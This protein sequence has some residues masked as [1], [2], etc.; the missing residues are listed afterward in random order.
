MKTKIVQ[1]THKRN[2]DLGSLLMNR[3]KL[4]L[5]KEAR[6]LG[7]TLDS[8]LTWKQRITRITRKA[9]TALMQCRQIVG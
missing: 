6:R 8:K 9:A 7:V 3:S 2:P 4:E 1:F 5:F